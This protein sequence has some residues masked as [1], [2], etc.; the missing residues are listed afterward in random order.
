[1]AIDPLSL[2]F[3]AVSTG[4]SLFQ[5]F[6]SQDSAYRKQ[7]QAVQQQNLMA[8]MQ[9]NQANL[10]IRKQTEYNAAAYE[11]KKGIV[12]QQQ[13]LNLEAAQR[14]YLGA[15]INRDR[16]LTALAYQRQDLAAELLEAVGANAAAIEGGNRSAQLAAAKRTYGRFGRMETQIGRQAEN[17]NTDTRLRSEDIQG[18]LKAANLQAHAQVAIAPYMQQELPPAFQMAGP[19]RPS[20]L[21]NALMI[22]QGLLGGASMYNSLAAPQDKIFSFDPSTGLRT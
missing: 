21:S 4:L 5:G 6:S 8:A 11:I 18:Q 17:I 20:G 13:A 12:K 3:A 7:K 22:G 15:A 16:Q 9:R 2:G 10:R 19:S 14:A 1:M